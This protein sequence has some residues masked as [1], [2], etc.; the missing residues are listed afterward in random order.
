MD[1]L[2]EIVNNLDEPELDV[3]KFLEELM[4]EI[5]KC[6]ECNFHRYSECPFEWAGY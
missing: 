6:S 4:E 5:E 2:E 1:W 3:D